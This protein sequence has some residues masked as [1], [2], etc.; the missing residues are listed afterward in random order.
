MSGWNRTPQT[1]MSLRLATVRENAVSTLACGADA[2]DGRIPLSPNLA[3][4]QPTAED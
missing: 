4:H 3:D 1:P 2:E